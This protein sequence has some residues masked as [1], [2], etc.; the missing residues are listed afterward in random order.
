MTHLEYSKLIVAIP[1]GHLPGE[2]LYILDALN[3][4]QEHSKCYT[5]S[6]SGFT[7]KYFK[8]QD[9]PALVADGVADVGFAYG[10]WIVEHQADVFPLLTFD[11]YHVSIEAITA[12]FHGDVDNLAS[13]AQKLAPEPLR[14]C[15]PYEHIART[16]LQAQNIDF[17]LRKIYGSAE[18]YPPECADLI[19]DC[20]ETG[21]TAHA[22]N[23]KVI[24]KLF[25]CNAHFIANTSLYHKRKEEML[26]ITQDIQNARLLMSH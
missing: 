5:R 26:A 22:N 25:H 18:A 14:V 7:C 10:E 20:V 4:T 8:V 21:E 17:V 16:Y 23:L 11:F 24:D 19:I 6:L 13:L 15:S 9:I 1:K 3:F 2:L 12:N